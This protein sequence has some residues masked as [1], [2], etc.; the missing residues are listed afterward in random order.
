MPN[1]FYFAILLLVSTSCISQNTKKQIT[2]QTLSSKNVKI[3]ESE[4]SIGPCEPSIF[5]NPKDPNNIVAGSII[6]YAHHS[7][8]G[9][10][11]W[12][13]QE[14][15]SDYGVWGDPVI[16]ADNDGVFYYLHLSDPEGTN[17]RSKKILDR[18]VIQRSDDGGKTWNKGSYFGHHEY[19]KQQDKQWATTD[20]KNNAVYATWTEF[21][22][23]GS[24]DPEH[25]SRILFSKSED[26][27][28]TW[29]QAITL[30][31]LE[32]DC[33]DDDLTTEGAVPATDGN[34]N[35]YVGWAYNSKIYFDR[36][37]DHG[38]TWLEKDIV[39][40]EQ[41]GGWTTEIPGLGRSNGM[42]ITL[43]DYSGGNQ[44][45][46]LYINYTDT[47]NGD[48]NS[49]VFVIR[50]FDQG[51]TWSNPVKVNNDNTNSH[52]FL[53]W[54][55]IDQSTGYLYVV[56]YDRSQYD[57]TKTDVVLAIS[58]DGGKSFSNQTISESPFDPSGCPFFGDYNN[59][60]AHNGV[61]RPIWT[62]WENNKLSIWTALIEDK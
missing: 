7:F 62:R 5:I 39:V 10:K 58:K 18:M 61:I 47:S 12:E 29:S 31:E 32:G 21:D 41:V 14:I 49:D 43:V 2:Y 48:D 13:T 11:T 50:S 35:L 15:S 40:T 57:D 26:G 4:N 60:N 37:E 55:D 3:F 44:D 6:N 16:V 54:M 53:T 23:Y 1:H 20:P 42:P 9:G 52:Q 46:N 59:I 36:S 38:K 27:S 56:Y 24:K 25:K 22:K 28:K 34:G 19:P 17:W 8:D 51:N 33:V 30:S 45:G